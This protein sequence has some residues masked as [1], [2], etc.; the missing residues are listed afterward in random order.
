MAWTQADIDAIDEA[1][2]SGASKV[3]YADKEVQYRSLAEM[4]S[5]RRDMADKVGGVKRRRRRV[6]IMSRGL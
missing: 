3:K 6:A 4:K 5:L 2:A 1:I